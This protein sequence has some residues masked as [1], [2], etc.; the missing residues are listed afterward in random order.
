[1]KKT[2]LWHVSSAP[3]EDLID[4]KATKVKQ[5]MQLNLMHIQPVGYPL[6]FHEEKDI[7]QSIHTDNPRLFEAYAREQWAG[8][9]VTEGDFLF[10]QFMVPD[11]AFEVKSCEPKK[12]GVIGIQTKILLDSKPKKTSYI[13]QEIPKVAFDEIIG[14]QQA[15]E[16]C[17]IVKN[18]LKD[19][20]RF[21]EWGPRSILFYGPPGTG[22][23]MMARALASE[24]KSGIFAISSTELIGVHVGDASRRISNLFKAAKAQAPC[25]I[26]LDELD[27]I[28]LDRSYQNIRGDVSE[29]V[30]A[31]LQQMDGITENKGVVTI[32]STNAPKLLD[33]AIRSRFEDEIEFQLPTLE[34]RIKILEMYINKLPLQIEVNIRKLAVDTESFSGRDLKEK[35]LKSALHQTLV[36]SEDLITSKQ[37]YETLSLIKKESKQ[38][39]L[40]KIF[41]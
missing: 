6:R 22:K 32:G 39:T 10:D 4:K 28:G 34:D 5:K 41:S 1:M 27:A 23:T 33:R 40:R 31:L 30:T 38:E 29:V 16:K 20:N 3:L 18:Y 14:H 24:T 12:G 25:I 35:L 19:P 26:F 15:K 21:S 11:F 9:Q 37:I 13:H 7:A 36:K 2:K 17:E 8:F